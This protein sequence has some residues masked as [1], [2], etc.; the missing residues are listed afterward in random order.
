MKKQRIFSLC[1]ASVLALSLAACQGQAEEQDSTP[2]TASVQPT[3]APTPEPTPPIPYTDVAEDSPYYNAVVWAYK[4][5][6]ASDGETFGPADACARGQVITFLWRAKGSPEPQ[7]TESPFSDVSSAD[8]FYK[9]ALWAYENGVV[10]GTA[11]NPGNP[12]TNSEAITVMWRAEGKPAAA[13]YS[14]PMA[15]AASGAYYERPV[16]WAENSGM[17][18]GLDS[19]FDPSAPCS[20]AAFMVYLNWA[21]EEWTFTEEDKTVQTEYEQIINDAQLFEVHGSGLLYADY[22]DTDGDGKAELLTIE[23][24]GDASGHHSYEVTA[25]VYA[26]ID[27]HAG[28]LCEQTFL[29]EWNEE[30]LSICKNDN[31]ACLR[32]TW[33]HMGTASEGDVSYKIENGAF[34]IHES[35]SVS[36]AS[37]KPEYEGITEAEY[38]ALDQ[39]YTGRKELLSYNRNSGI[40]VYDRGLLPRADEYYRER[41]YPAVLNGDFSFF[42]G[43]YKCGYSSFSDK[44]N[45]ILNKDGTLTGGVDYFHATNQK[46]ISISV[47]ANG[48]IRCVLIPVG[49]NDGFQGDSYDIYPIGVKLSNEIYDDYSVEDHLGP[50]KLRIIYTHWGGSAGPSD[51]QYYKVH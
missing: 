40:S 35:I 46:P 14:S 34:V 22:V 45:L 30:S 37:E 25:T 39:K 26:N 43:T 2:P 23:T 7:A 12:C 13:V 9:P 47:M 31:R 1:L 32:N 42:A 50:E 5:G 16:A 17:F 48:V 3:I 18:A 4:N 6:I 24:P 44:E 27:G 20:R 36:Y 51:A 15:L 11:F 19:T 28:K 8:W 49:F 21:A 10:T 29:W 41:I 33:L 38:N